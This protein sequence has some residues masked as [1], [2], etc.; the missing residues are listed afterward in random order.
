MKVLI[1][2]AKL[3]QNG[4]LSKGDILIDR[5]RIVKIAPKIEAV[6]DKVINAD[7][8]CV[9]PGFID[10]HVH[11][12]DPGQTYKEDI[13]SGTKAAAHGGFTAICAMPNTEPITDNIASVEYIQLR[14]KELGSS[15]VYVIGAIT[16]KSE[17]E[18]IAEMATMKSGG[19]VAVSDDGK[20][21]QNAR[22]MLS[23]MKYAANFNIPVII[24]AEDYNLAGKGQIHGG[25]IAT[26]VGL[27]GIPGLAEEVIIARD[28]MLAESAGARLHIA[29]ISTAKSL[30]L[31][32]RAKER[33]LPITC[34][35]TPHHLVLNEEA[36]LHF[37]TNTKMK[38]PLRSESDRLAC[39]QA[40]KDGLIDCI[41]T[42]HAPHADFEKEKEFDYAPFGII[43]LETAFPVLYKH[44]V[45]SKQISLACLVNALSS[46]PAKVLNLPGGSL[47]EGVAADVT[48]IDLKQETH[49]TPQNILSKSKNTPW[50]N[51]SL[52]G[53]VMWTICSGNITY[54]NMEKD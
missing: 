32:R 23:C 42:D 5:K 50:L 1:I 31:V 2:N 16:K 54:Q 10:L 30:E 18:E 21:V 46:S 26:Q 43:G 45:L 38:P 51:Q 7:G 34:E 6:V 39:V 47:K 14:A 20:C 35:V 4:K 15:K 44:L 52:P 3:Y 25:K 29:H 19:I 40:L 8:A 48:I 28:I 11:L 24:H 41:A 12:R 9:F 37:D 27:S 22:L 17:G 36:C 49:F 13:V 53:K 33:G